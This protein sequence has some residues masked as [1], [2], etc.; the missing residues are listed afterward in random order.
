MA[1]LRSIWD[2]LRYTF[3]TGSMVT[4]LIIVN[5][6]IFVLVN[7]AL[8]FLL[9]AKGA[10]EGRFALQEGLEWLCM[11]ASIRT[12]LYQLWSPLTH[13]FLHE[14]FWHV[15]NNIAFLSIF[16]AVVSDLLGNRRVLPVYLLGGL[17]GGVAFMLS[18]QFVPYVGSYA[19][20]ASG[21]VMALG[22]AAMVMAPDY[23]VPLFLLGDVKVKY[24]VIVL[25]LF[26]LIGVANKYNSGGHLAHLGGFAMGCLF[27]YRLRD[28][29][30]L[31]EPVNRT[32]D[33]VS[34]W[35]SGRGSLTVSHSRG[36]VKKAAAGAP[37]TA[38]RGG[39]APHDEAA[40]QQQQLDDILSKIKAGGY[41]SLTA[42][43]KEFLYN[44][45]K[46]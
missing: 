28:G 26:D 30:D 25:L 1:L 24:I 3:R 27:V 19:L 11:P 20:G 34:G 18:A 33:Y 10:D 16:G 7:I 4:L 8:L 36:K 32:L 37:F 41:E 35:F 6:G 29:Q 14:S 39:Q 31:A 21:A 46:R 23:R 5:F 44:A 38:T 2:D 22:G 43:E 17:A 45:S 9:V 13:M 42:E 15:V 12:L 40:N